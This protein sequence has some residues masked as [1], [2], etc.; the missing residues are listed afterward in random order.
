[1]GAS[2]LLPGGVSINGELRREFRFR[3]ITGALELQLGESALDAGSRPQ[4]VTR[5]LTSALESIGGEPVSAETVRALSVGDRQFLM[6]QLAARLDSRR[7]WLTAR[8]NGCREPFDLAYR[9]AELP[10]KPAGKGYPSAR[11]RTSIGTVIART[12]TGA[13]QELLAAAPGDEDAL[14]VLLRCLLNDGNDD[15]TLAQLSE[16]DIK[17]IEQRLEAAA[18]EVATELLAHCPQCGHA[19]LISVDPC[20][21]ARRPPA[22]LFADVHTLALYYHWSEHEILAMPRGRRHT[23]LRLIDKSRGMDGPADSPKAT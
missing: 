7:V 2:D 15:L 14:R 21:C 10:V 8:C 12:P 17:A 20:Q 1:M 5:V 22:E 11:V 9:H 16:A 18:P 4:R 6:V 23:Y 3:P 19:N 13:D